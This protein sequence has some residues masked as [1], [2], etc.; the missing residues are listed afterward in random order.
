MQMKKFINDNKD[1]EDVEGE[2]KTQFSGKN[3]IN[4]PSPNVYDT[5]YDIQVKL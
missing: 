2:R 1:E 4:D 5:N 3:K